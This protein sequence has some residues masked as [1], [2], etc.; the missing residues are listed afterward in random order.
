MFY[1]DIINE[2]YGPVIKTWQPQAIIPV[3]LHSSKY[4]KRGY[5][6][7]EVLAKELSTQL[8]IPV[9]STSLLRIKNTVPQKQLNDRE[10]CN[11]IINAFQ[12]AKNSVKYKKVLL[13]DDIYTTGITIDEC[14]RVLKAEGAELVFFAVVCIGRGF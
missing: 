10:R 5:N 9:D 7:A 8:N 14:A 11:N 13:V 12:M 2:K 4:R 3:P 1:A 6:Q